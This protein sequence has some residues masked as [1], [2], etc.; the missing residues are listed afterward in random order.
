MVIFITGISSGFGK[1]IAERL[2]ADGHK[3]YGTFRK[4]EDFLPGVHYIKA[5]STDMEDVQR[6]VDE[7]ITAEGHMDVFV[8]NAGMGIGG[9]LEFAPMEDC[10]RI[11]DV[12]FMGLVRYAR[13]IVPVMRRQ[14]YGHIVCMSSIGGVVG[15]PYQGMYSA[16]KFAVEAYC[17]ALRLELKASG[18]NVTVVE[19]GDFATGFT[20]TRKKADD[21]E[22]FAA[23][24]SYARSMESIEHDE[25]TGLT[26]DVLARKISRLV[27][28]KRPP[29]RMVVATPLQ[30]LAVAAKVLLPARTFAWIMKL[31]YKL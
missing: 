11:M 31:Y 24:P 30:K 6:A 28:R 1:A 15:L 29:Y 20:A 2:Q 16:S 21:S 5:D 13:A 19:P 18:V 23:Y 12:N 4:T 17:E 3:V 14:G 22:V 26:P 8:N 10:N 7:V 25:N 27:I 9:P